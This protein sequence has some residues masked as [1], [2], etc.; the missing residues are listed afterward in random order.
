MN[1]S[2]LNIYPVKST[3]AQSLT[4]SSVGS[5]GLSDDRKWL[6]IDEKNQLITGRDYP[7]LLK[8]STSVANET[9]TIDSP[10][11]SIHFHAE[12]EGEADFQFFSEQLKGSFY[13]K[14]ADHW[15][16]DYLDITCRLIYQN[17]I[18]RSVLEKRGGKTG[19]TMNYGDEAP[20]L[21]IGEASLQEL[22]GRL[23]KPIIMA[24]F[25]PNIVIKGSDA[26]AEDHWKVI[27]IGS[28]E[29]QVAQACKRCVFTTIDPV[30]LE[31]SSSGEPLRT[32]AAYRKHAEGGVAFGVHLIPRKLG[33]I[34]VGDEAEVLQ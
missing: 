12:T 7:A 23:E 16:S 15:F 4:S 13:S 5:E 28:V 9:L 10:G 34:S 25:R 27:R 3:K 31:K 21:L 32:L 14:E 29:F 19:D 30:T 1:V 2:E 17:E 18:P 8:L 33:K 24:H 20:I 22:N 11:G 6:L 26:Y